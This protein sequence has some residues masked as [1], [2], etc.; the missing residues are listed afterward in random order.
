MSYLPYYSYPYRYS[1]FYSDLSTIPTTT[2][3]FPHPQ[4]SRQKSF[5]PDFA[6]PDSRP[7]SQLTLLSEDPE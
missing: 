6:A 5:L 1:K 7:R 4:L 2:L 3:S